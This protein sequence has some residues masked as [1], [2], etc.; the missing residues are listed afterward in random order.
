MKL[1]LCAVLLALCA[2]PPAYAHSPV[3]GIEGFYIGLLDPLSA[4]PQVLVLLGLGLLMA[5]F[6]KSQAVWQLAAFLVATLVGI[7]FG[8]GL[9]TF[10]IPLLATAT[11]AGAMAALAPAR[12]LAVCVALA[13]IGGFYVGAVSIPDPGPVRDRIITVAGSFVGANLAVL[14]IFGA[15]I[16]AKE[17]ATAPWLGTALRAVAGGVAVI[18]ALLLA[19]QSTSGN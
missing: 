2:A 5:S 13:A 19:L 14:Y 3:P 9:L 17:K 12:A 16:Y 18:A 15:I 10:N 6:E 8:A 7:V 1:R 4:M 11:V